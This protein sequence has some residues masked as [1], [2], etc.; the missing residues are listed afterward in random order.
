MN[1][2]II[3][4]A[5]ALSAAALLFG[6]QGEKQATDFTLTASGLSADLNGK[7]VYVFAMG[8][9]PIDSVLVTDGAFTL[10]MD[11]ASNFDVYTLSDRVTGAV[12]FVPEAGKAELR[13]ETGTFDGAAVYSVV[14]EN[15]LNTKVSEY[16][17]RK[18]NVEGPL[19]ARHQAWYEKWQKKD[20][21]PAEEVEG[22]T[23]E[24]AEIDSV[25]TATMNAFH[26]S[27]YDAN[28]DN[29]VG[30]LV[31]GYLQFKDEKEYISRYEEASEAVKE[32]AF[33]K[34]NYKLMKKSAETAVGAKYV[35][36][37]MKDDQGVTKKISDLWKP[38]TYLLID[39]WASWCGPCRAAMP[40]LSGL[41]K[42]IGDKLTVLSI[43]GLQET[44][45]QNEK[46]KAELNMDWTTFFDAES[47]A[48]DV[49]GVTAI[50]NLVLIA[51]DGTILVRTNDPADVDA[52]LKEVGIL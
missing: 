21:L 48:A 23:A 43:G 44:R 30:A 7:Y 40:H 22:L 1:T 51:P 36:V 49:Y 8:R 45:E 20:S 2:P 31:F 12:S 41:N 14:P 4:T 10:V 16:T 32:Y 39:F 17:K 34:E 47:V 3:R 52:K 38:E 46:A 18:S 28:K 15:G 42:T 33:N 13:T 35:D 5:L 6:C 29:I 37:E 9:Q 27:E 25:Y 50:P 11:S 19:L 26:Q 24:K